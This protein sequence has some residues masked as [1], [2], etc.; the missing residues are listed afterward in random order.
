MYEEKSEEKLKQEL[1]T[2][3]TERKPQDSSSSGPDLEHIS[4][5]E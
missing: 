5:D 3:F 2:F 1:G 4:S